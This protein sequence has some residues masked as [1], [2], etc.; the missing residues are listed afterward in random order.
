[1]ENRTD[2]IHT[3]VITLLGV[4]VAALVGLTVMAAPT[5][6]ASDEVTYLSGD[7][8]TYG[9]YI[10]DKPGVYRLAEDISFDPNSPDTL[11]L[12]IENGVIPAAA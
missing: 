6:G 1:M 2:R 8:F 4:A 10:I 11:S 7:D 5:N 12:A 9:T 3:I